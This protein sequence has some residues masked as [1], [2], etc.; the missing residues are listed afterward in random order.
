MNAID[1][2]SIADAFTYSLSLGSSAGNLSPAYHG[3][4]PL[5]VATGIF[6][7]DT[8]HWQ[9]TVS[10]L[11]GD[12]AQSSG[13]II[14]PPNPPRGMRLI[15]SKDSSFQ[16]GNDYSPDALPIHTV[17]I[18]CDYW[19]D[20]TEVTQESYKALMG[21][22]PSSFTGNDYRPVEKVTWFDAVIYCNKRSRRD[23][24]D[25]V[26]SYTTVTKSGVTC[27]GLT[28]LTT[29]LLKKGYR[30]P[31]EAEWE[32]ACRAGTI[33]DYYWGDKDSSAGDFAWFY[34]NSETQTHQV[35][36]KE[37]NAFGLYDMAG[38]VYEWCNDWYEKWSTPA[39]KTD[40]T[41]MISGTEHSIRGGSWNDGAENL[42]S[43]YR[44][45]DVP[46]Y[47]T[48]GDVGFRCVRL[49]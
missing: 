40:P 44:V 10:D 21:I 1:P 43:G 12:S 29:D 35:A 46:T 23:S 5:Y 14:A 3:K 27:I 4:E 18:T 25:T 48:L 34:Q 39:A 6:S 16:M 19:I 31:T 2:D 24:L 47:R 17:T 26:Y 37:P 9:C 42:L 41:G 13:I 49:H 33:S 45:R 28:D 20:T 30:L 36:L 38:N 32:F 11:F 7:L 8:L 15:H 22:N